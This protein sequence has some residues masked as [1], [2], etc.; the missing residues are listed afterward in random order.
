MIKEAHGS[1]RSIR[2][3]VLAVMIRIE[4][5]RLMYI[6]HSVPKDCT[7]IEEQSQKVSQGQDLK[8]VESSSFI[9]FF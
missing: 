9:I 7:N 3:L 2:L 6:T 1:N 8:L 5:S 4:F